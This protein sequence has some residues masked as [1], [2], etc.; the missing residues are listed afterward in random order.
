MTGQVMAVGLHVPEGP[1]THA[2]GSITFTEQ[3][4]GRI[5]RWQEGVTS[6]V[7]RTGGAPNSHVV[8]RNGWIL[9]AQNGGVVGS[10]RSNDP[11]TPSVQL[12]RPGRP[13]QQWCEQVNGLPLGAPNDLTFGP[14]GALYVTDPGHAFNAQRRGPGGQILRIDPTGRASRVVDTGPTFCNGIAFDPDGRLLWVESYERTVCTLDRNG[15]RT[16]LAILPPGHVPDGLAVAAD[17]RLF[18]ATCGSHGV[19]VLDHR[20]HLVDHLVL[21]ENANA[22]NCAL[23]AMGALWVTD[24]G[25]QWEH[26]PGSGRLWR[27]DTAAQPLATTAFELATKIRAIDTRRQY[28]V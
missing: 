18:I 1:V 12:V 15:Q 16:V 5:S 26:R 17:G 20:A 19:T 4:A 7:V 10:W 23:D 9:V 13:P 3:T 25:M 24:F 28:V 22:T 11:Q 27:L 8:A 6:E 14:D 21:D 2:D